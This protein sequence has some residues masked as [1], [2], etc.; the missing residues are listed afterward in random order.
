MVIRE[1]TKKEILMDK[2]CENLRNFSREKLEVMHKSKKKRRRL[3]LAELYKSDVNVI[4]DLVSK[5]ARS[6]VTVEDMTIEDATERALADF[7]FWYSND[8]D[9]KNILE[10]MVYGE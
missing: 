4:A 8:L 3:S 9:K 1:A 7:M 6:Y 5:A 2:H 10:K